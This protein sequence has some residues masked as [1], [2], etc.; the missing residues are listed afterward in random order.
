MR[1]TVIFLRWLF[2]SVFLAVWVGVGGIAAASAG[3]EADEADAQA[4]EAAEA[5]ERLYGKDVE[6]VRSTREPDDDVALAKRL[7][8]TAREA[9][10]TPALLAVLCEK[11]CDLAAGH[12]GGW[13]TTVEA[14]EFLAA[15]VPAKAAACAERVAEVRRK[16]YAAADGD[17]KAAA[18]EALID[19]LLALAEAHVA[20][21][22]YPQ[23]ISALKKAGGIARAAGSDRLAAL[24]AR[25][26]RAQFLLRT[27]RDIE[28]MKALIARE[29]ENT[30]AREKLVRLHLVNLDDPAAAAK[31]L[32]GVEDSGLKKYVPAV[33][34][35]V[36]AAPE[37]A[38]V[39]LGDWYRT[40]GETA[41][42]PARRAMFARAKAYYQRFLSLHEAED[43]ER[44]TATLALKKVETNLS[45]LAPAEAPA[46]A[47]GETATAQPAGTAAV[48]KD[49]V[50]KPGEWVDLLPLVDPQKDA[51]EGKWVQTNAGLTAVPKDGLSR[52]AIPVALE[53]S[54]VLEAR[55]VRTKGEADIN[56]TLP[57]GRTGVTA[58]FDQGKHSALELV[59]GKRSDENGTSV[60]VRLE[61]GRVYRALIQVM[62][63]GD[64]AAIT[65]GLNGKGIIRWRGPQ[66]ALSVYPP[67]KVPDARCLGL[68]TWRSVATF[69][70]IRLRMLSG[71]A[72]LLRP[73]AGAA[74]PSTAPP[75]TAEPSV[76]KPAETAAVPAGRIVK[77]GEWV[78]LLPL[79]DPARHGLK[80]TWEARDGGVALVK[81]AGGAR[82]MLPAAPVGEYDL[83]VTFAR[84]WGDH[85]I[86]ATLPIGTAGVA[87]V[88]NDDHG[89]CDGLDALDGKGPGQNETRTAP[90]RLRDR[91]DCIVHAAVRRAGGGVGIDVT[92]DGKPHLAWQGPASRLSVGKRWKL[93]DDRFLG[94]GAHF[95]R[96]HWKRV[97][98]K[99]HSGMARVL[100]AE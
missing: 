91:R 38:C 58:A 29:P 89:A 80:G 53:G 16:Q 85:A 21:G 98:L 96:V 95:T 9:T 86:V 43:L 50:I 4:R 13:A 45:Q 83:E 59:D 20:A 61:N 6:R 57:V 81:A 2:F 67:W 12:A 63:S 22:A 19:S 71:E 54:Y 99:M 3:A 51:V 73:A 78:D 39:E 1:Q 44:T 15:Q 18:G 27:E 92:V 94:L 62:V 56:F 70:R 48:P 79:V 64:E 17:A 34:K 93:P 5:L 10:G 36:A 100:G 46:K 60:P 31:H 52:L 84:T 28:N 30:A 42:A 97:R 7:L 82:L 23:A 14:A 49:G 47:T 40:L 68:V 76:P 74:T 8:A 41:Q 35:G 55:F 87:V 25:E 24:E 77:P 72:R 11:A 75:S 26:Q 32:E 69:G 90:V 88:L 33:G 37:L 66:S 65:V